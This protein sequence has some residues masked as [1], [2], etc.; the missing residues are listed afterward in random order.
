VTVYAVVDGG[1]SP[2]RPLADA[3]ETFT[4]RET[5]SAS[6]K[7]SGDDPGLAAHPR[8]DERELETGGTTSLVTGFLTRVRCR[9][10]AS[11]VSSR[12]QKTA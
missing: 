4:R 8:I 10:L 5:R 2:T 3:V 1:L 6:S 11:P 12:F 7:S 9:L